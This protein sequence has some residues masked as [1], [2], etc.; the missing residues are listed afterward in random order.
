M[1]SRRIAGITIEIDGNTTK[2]NDSLKSVDKQLASTQSQLKDVE[3]L[4]KLDPHNTEL[5]A[6]KQ[7]L[8]QDSISGT[9]DR[10]AEL[11]K[12]SAELSKKDSTPEL[13]KQ[14]AALQREIVETKNKL[15]GFE[16]ELGKIPNK[17]QIAFETVGKSLQD[18]GKKI[19]EVGENMT[20]YVT[21]PIVGVGTAAVAAFSEVD[22]AM[23]NVIKM[24]GAT[25]E[26]LD[27]LQKTVENLATTIPTSFDEASQA[28]GE[29]NTKFGVTGQE[30]EDLSASFI[31]FAQ[32]NDTT[33]A[34]SVDRTQRLMQNFG[35]ETKDASKVLDV[36]NRTAQKT[37]IK[38]D[39]LADLMN[40]NADSLQ[41]MGMNAS[42]AAEFLG[43]VEMSG[44]DVSQVMKALQ[45]VNKNATKQGKTMNQVLAEFS[46]YMK[47]NATDAEKSQRAIELFGSNAGQAIYN[48]AKQ[49][50]LSFS[51]MSS[52]LDSFAGSVE[53]TF[54]GTVDGIDNW[55]MAMNEVK[56][57]GSDIGG[58][59]SEFAG[60]ILAKVRDA[61]KEAVGWWRGLSEQQQEMILKIGGI[62]AAIGPAI[63]L[64]GKLTSTIGLL[65]QGIGLL[66][67]HPILAGI[68]LAVTAIGGLVIAIKEAKE[69]EEAERQAL[70]GINEEM[71]QTINEADELNQ[72]YADLNG[73]REA[74]FGAMDSEYQYLQDLAEEY[75][76][77]LDDNGQ[78]IDKYKERAEFIETTLSQAL[79][80]EKSDIEEIIK[81]NGELSSS[82]DE[83][84]VKRKAEMYLTQMQNDYT[85]AIKTCSDAQEKLLT[86][87]EE[88]ADLTKTNNKLTKEHEKLT[89]AVEEATIAAANG[90]EEHR[91]ALKEAE[92]ALAENEAAL[93]TNEDAMAEM[94][95]TIAATT[96]TYE[97]AQATIANYNGVASAM[98]EGDVNKIN[99]ALEGASRNFQ[100]TE[101]ATKETLQ[102][103]VKD[104]ETEYARAEAS[105]KRGSKLI[106][107]A[108]LDEKKY[109]L[110]Q[111]KKE[112][113]KAEKAAKDSATAQTQG[114][115]EKIR[116]GR[117]D[118]EGAIQYVGGG[119]T[120]ELQ[121]VSNKAEDY[122]YYIDKGLADGIR[123]NQ[124][125]ATYA[126]NN[127]ANA[128]NNVLE[129]RWL[130]NSPSKL[131]EWMGHMLDEG[132]A[133][134]IDGGEAVKAANTLANDV[135]GQ[136]QVQKD[137]YTNVPQGTANMVE[138]FS[139]ALSRMKVEMDDR[140]MGRFVENTVVKAV[141]A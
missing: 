134:G 24:T 107:Q 132:L 35:I 74:L 123:R 29:I 129:N 120:N 43:Q 76:S 89:R 3:K 16:D 10:L 46:T 56:L 106:T 27:G 136:F 72:K 32:L 78:I 137:A 88:Y 68:G 26:E 128:V 38:V 109:W 49:G 4:L 94:E 111:A 30:L 104:Y 44:A 113:A 52:T 70:Y 105:V 139:V 135:A 15:K 115:A 14:Q 83:I 37:G 90:D 73:N 2:L 47:G 92:K 39:K 7:K 71:R 9:K 91:N 77:Y 101:T 86:L 58:I 54:E 31:K 99:H 140:E 60:P 6:Q 100:T 5:L 41:N 97:G 119:V 85:E 124:H 133:I 66:A 126:A 34:D 48:A 75:D 127:M 117:T 19:S 130:I 13:E 25:G 23:D 82:I 11:E 1:A 80:L 61:L 33:V 114:Y 20:K 50:N 141:Y 8:L 81:K 36:L 51:S 62:V 110:E 53:Q 122:G 103:Q 112:L 102:K 118:V 108:D 64:I 63:S 55:K 57:I 18:A 125:L 59:L 40:D 42:E 65:S 12:A 45:K 67:A 96:Q 17:A 138:A 95:E 21:A 116:R 69:A 79:G 22:D 28:V 131:T 98:V 93:K 121:T 84:I 87:E